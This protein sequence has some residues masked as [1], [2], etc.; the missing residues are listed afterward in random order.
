MGKNIVDNSVKT[1]GDRFI[2]THP[3]AHFHIPHKF[4]QSFVKLISTCTLL[5][6]NLFPAVVYVYVNCLRFRKIGKKN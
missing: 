3:S 6:E 5:L 1:K 4:V 2:Q